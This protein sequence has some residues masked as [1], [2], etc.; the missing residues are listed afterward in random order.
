ML[1]VGC[2]PSVRESN[3]RT[4]QKN[5]SLVRRGNGQVT[6]H[7]EGA[8]ELRLIRETMR[9]IGQLPDE[10]HA[11]LFGDFLLGRG[12]HTEVEPETDGSWSVWVVEEE[13]LSDAQR[14]L[15]QFRANPN[16]AE[17]HSAPTEAQRVREAEARDRAAYQKRV[18][19]GQ[20]LF[21]KIGG[22]GFGFLTYALIFACVVVA[23]YSNLGHNDEFLRKL[24]ITDPEGS[25]YRF[26]PDV[27]SG[28][29]WRLLTPIFIHFGIVH[30]LF[31]MLWLFDLGC[32]IEARR[33]PLILAAL[34]V[35]I[36]VGSNLAQFVITHNPFFG[37]MSG[38]VYGL[39]GY[40]WIQ[41]K[42]NRASGL[43]LDSRSATI[44]LVWLALCYTNL[45]GPVAN[46]AHLAGLV[47]GVAWGGLA[48]FLSSGNPR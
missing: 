36:G 9:S 3:V 12:V 33:S 37:G 20:S 7:V 32:M 13:R 18:R 31:N 40:V 5:L 22:Y 24:Y 28:Q 35:V 42:Y 23:I 15:E 6:S 21:P 43:F 47:M 46:T 4:V 30:L 39:A 29:V 14:W 38:V 44:L 1:G 8:K 2:F 19:T 16:A 45:L 10:R 11:R 48:A 41:G 25:P 26:L 34:V 17:F 27:F